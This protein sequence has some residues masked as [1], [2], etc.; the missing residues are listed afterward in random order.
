MILIKSLDNDDSH[1]STHANNS[2]NNNN[3]AL[4][5]STAALWLSE[6]SA[7]SDFLRFACM[8]A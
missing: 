8:Q 7:P 4:K 2:N 6:R 3:L 5:Q 1:D